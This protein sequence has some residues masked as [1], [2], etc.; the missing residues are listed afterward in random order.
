MLRSPA[1]GHDDRQRVAGA[2]G[3]DSA[4]GLRTA[5]ELSNSGV[6]RGV[7]VTDLGQMVQNGGPESGGELPVQRHIEALPA[8]VEVLIKLAGDTSK[9]SRRTQ[10]PR[11]DPLGQAS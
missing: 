1:T 6:A 9:T 4:H 5:G 8:M 11:A 3:A 2:G 7:A 10:H